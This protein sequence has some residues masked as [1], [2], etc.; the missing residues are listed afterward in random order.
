LGKA[1]KI[2]FPKLFPAN[3][4]DDISVQNNLAES[5]PKKLNELLELHKAWLISVRFEKGKYPID[6]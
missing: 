3:L 5:N 6:Y 4:D 2:D 1:E